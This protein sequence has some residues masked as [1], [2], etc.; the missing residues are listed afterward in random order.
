MRVRWDIWRLFH[1]NGDRRHCRFLRF[2]SPGALL[3]LSSDLVANTLMDG[4]S[5]FSK[6]K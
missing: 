5:T 3:M 1:S 4:N 6:H 2:S